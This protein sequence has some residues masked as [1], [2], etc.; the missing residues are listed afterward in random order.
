ML[1][2]KEKTEVRKYRRKSLR[3]KKYI[4]SDE[5]HFSSDKMFSTQKTKK[6]S[7]LRKTDISLLAVILKES[8]AFTFTFSQG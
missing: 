1:Y 8:L 2:Q 7:G 6:N 3:H 4:W 5:A